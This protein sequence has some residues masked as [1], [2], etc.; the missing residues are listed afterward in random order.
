MSHERRSPLHTIIGFAELPRE[1]SMGLL[2][3]AQKRF[4]RHVYRDSLHL[5]D[6][7]NDLLGPQQDRS[8]A[9]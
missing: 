8:R 3:E 9:P 4:I 5:S 2:N 6:L 7:I 1:E